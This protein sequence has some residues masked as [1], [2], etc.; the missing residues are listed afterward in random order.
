MRKRI[1]DPERVHAQRGK[2]H[3]RVRVA[4]E[5]AVGKHAKQH[6]ERDQHGG[7]R[8]F[9]HADAVEAEHQRAERQSRQ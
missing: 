1:A 7:F 4:L 8:P 2:L 3:Q 6:G 5:M 9:A